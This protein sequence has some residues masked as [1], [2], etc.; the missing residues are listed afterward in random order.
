MKCEKWNIKTLNVQGPRVLSGDNDKKQI[1]SFG[2]RSKGR[3]CRSW[4]WAQSLMADACRGKSQKE[5]T[6][7]NLPGLHRDGLVGR[8]EGD[9][10]VC[11]RKQF[12]SSRSWSLLRST[13]KPSQR[14]QCRGLWRG[15]VSPMEKTDIAYWD[16]KLFSRMV[17]SLEAFDSQEEDFLFLKSDYALRKL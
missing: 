8:T 10:P 2:R 7:M 12:T 4:P 1:N 6:Y 3:I 5:T 9:L 15:D 17:R 13:G 14:I 16:S 11:V